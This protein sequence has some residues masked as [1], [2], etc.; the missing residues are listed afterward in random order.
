MDNVNEAIYIGVSAMIFVIALSLTIFLFSSMMNYAEEAYDFM[1]EVS[2]DGAV[3][4]TAVNRYLVI[5]SEDVVSYY[6]NYIQKD[7]FNNPNYN[8]NIVVSINYKTKDEAPVYLADD[9]TYEGLIDR[10]GFSNKFILNVEDNRQDRKT[11][12]N[13]IRATDQELEEKW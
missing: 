11:Y 10:I 6:Y 9:L 13:I 4:N 2:N 7:R 12:I 3:I 8:E 1:H 5:S